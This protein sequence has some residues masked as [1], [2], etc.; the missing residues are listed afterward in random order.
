MLRNDF[1]L[2]SGYLLVKTALKV[3]EQ[4][5]SSYDNLLLVELVFVVYPKNIE[6]T[7]A[8]D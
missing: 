3:P 1:L 4:I 6:T 2:F 5:V 7:V 8:G